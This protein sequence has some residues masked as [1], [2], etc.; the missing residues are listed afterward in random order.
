MENIN[1]SIVFMTVVLNYDA[2]ENMPE[3]FELRNLPIF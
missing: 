1:E 2:M 3:V